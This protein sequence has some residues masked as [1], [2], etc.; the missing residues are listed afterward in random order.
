MAKLSAVLPKWSEGPFTTELQSSR[1]GNGQKTPPLTEALLVGNRRWSR[2]TNMRFKHPGCFPFKST[3][4]FCSHW[5]FLHTSII[6][7]TFCEM[8]Y[9]NILQDSTC[10]DSTGFYMY[11][12]YSIW[13]KWAW[14]ANE[15]R[16]FK[17]K[18]F[19]DFNCH[20]KTRTLTLRYFFGATRNPRLGKKNKSSVFLKSRNRKWWLVY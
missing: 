17:D 4:P 11:R 20:L 5:P 10:T 2:L 14:W 15:P 1:N 12:F 9:P 13:W 16:A 3:G 6:N 7:M 19:I 18:S 8:R